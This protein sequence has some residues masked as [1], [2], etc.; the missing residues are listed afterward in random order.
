LIE[1]IN[2][3]SEIQFNDGLNM[4]S[5]TIGAHVRHVVEHYQSLLLD[6]DTIDYD[7]RSRNNA[8]ETQPSTAIAT[9]NSLISVL[10]KITTDKKVDVLCST[11]TAPQTNPTTSSLRRELVFVHSHTTHHMAII[12]ILALSMKLPISINF[13]KAASTQK[14]EHNVQS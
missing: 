2:T 8:I 5:G 11:N 1:F 9:L 3:L 7:N 13:G 12:R 14:F 4:N 10:Q 6:A